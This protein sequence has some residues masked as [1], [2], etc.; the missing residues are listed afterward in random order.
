MT[1]TRVS[2]HQTVAMVCS[3]GVRRAGTPRRPPFGIAWRSPAPP[4]EQ[5]GDRMTTTSI[6]RSSAL[7]L[8]A[9]E[10]IPLLILTAVFLAIA[11]YIRHEPL[12]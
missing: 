4:I 6:V 5:E 1:R 8:R 2:F 9:I 3:L 12:F 7:Y 11:V 10:G